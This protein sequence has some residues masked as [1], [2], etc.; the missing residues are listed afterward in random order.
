MGVVQTNPQT[1]R[2]LPRHYYE[3]RIKIE[4]VR[5]GQTIC[6]GGWVRD[7]S[8]SGVG[9]FAGNKLAI[10]ERTT[11]TIPLPNQSELVV[12]A[13]ITRA[14]GTQYGFQ[15]TALN[16]KQRE[17]LR[18]VLAGCKVVVEDPRSY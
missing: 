16:G 8:E 15:F 6:A 14:V 11:L 1:S 18:K 10:G 9:A 5:E 13:I 3:A 7:L 12:P 4:V 2:I 17:Q